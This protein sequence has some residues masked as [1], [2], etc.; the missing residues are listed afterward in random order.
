MC[1]CWA[2]ALTFNGFVRT[3]WTLAKIAF[4]GQFQP[5]LANFALLAAFTTPTYW[6]TAKFKPIY[7]GRVKMAKV[8][9][10]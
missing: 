5:I 6:G 7:R 9:T 3:I 1:I 10:I 2:V 8:Q 4:S